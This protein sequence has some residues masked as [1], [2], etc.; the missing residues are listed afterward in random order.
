MKKLTPKKPTGQVPKTILV[1]GGGGYIGS[2][3]VKELLKKGYQ[4]IVFDNLSSGYKQ[5]VFKPA[6]LIIGDLLDIKKL[7]LLFKKYQFGAVIHFAGSIEAEESMERP[8]DFFRNNVVSSLNLLETMIC[9][10]VRYLIF[11][12]SAA[13]YGEARENPID[14]DAEVKPINCYG[15]TKM[16]VEEMLKY[17]DKIHGLRYISLRYFNAAGA[18]SEGNLGEVHKPETHL[19]PKI[20]KESVLGNKPAYIYGTDYKTPDG[21]CIRDYIHVSDLAQAHILAFEYLKAKNK[22]EIFNLG[23]EKG[24]SVKEIIDLTKK[25]TGIDFQVLEDKKRPGD[26]AILVASSKKAK[27]KLRWEPRYNIYDIIE[28]AYRWHKNHPK[29][30]K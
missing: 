25:I 24:N 17:F 23:T 8:E 15:A 3:T 20:L 29:G 4:V 16:I 10:K 12:S 26:P 1:T 7:K 11:S 28:T 6:K 14:E 13:V 5:A 21:T 19:I 30:Y 18:D 27:D 9:Y 2:H 22:S